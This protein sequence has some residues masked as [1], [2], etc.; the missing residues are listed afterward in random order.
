M[1]GIFMG[2]NGRI[3]THTLLTMVLTVY[4]IILHNKKRTQ[5]SHGGKWGCGTDMHKNEVEFDRRKC[6]HY[7]FFCWANVCVNTSIRFEFFLFSVMLSVLSGE[8]GEFPAF[9]FNIK[10]ILTI[11]RQSFCRLFQRCWH[12]GQHWMAIKRASSRSR[13][14]FT[15]W[16]WHIGTARNEHCFCR[17][18]LGRDQ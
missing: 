2:A 14:C 9:W 5:I 8:L 3:F 15:V 11:E 1:E 17:Y 7:F 4:I 10:A 18:Q 13:E 16:Q 12:L 6:F